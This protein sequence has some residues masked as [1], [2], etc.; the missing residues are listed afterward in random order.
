MA[1]K[2]LIKYDIYLYISTLN[3]KPVK[4]TLWSDTCTAFFIC[5]ISVEGFL[6]REASDLDL[7]LNA[8]NMVGVALRGDC[9][10][11]FRMSSPDLRRSL[12]SQSAAVSERPL[13]ALPAL[14]PLA[15]TCK[16]R[17]CA[18]LQVPKNNQTL[19]TLGLTINLTNS[20]SQLHTSH[21]A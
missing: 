20:L 10:V 11:W 17:D 12:R 8:S 2:Q 15:L 19:I 5:A 7:G 14:L 13:L 16:C 21:R 1:S 9:T 18:M 3:H 6:V 4:C